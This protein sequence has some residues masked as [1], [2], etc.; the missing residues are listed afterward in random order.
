MRNESRGM[1]LMR[2]KAVTIV[3]T[4]TAAVVSGGWLLRNGA[5][6]PTVT[7]EEGRRL[8]QQVISLAA[9]KFVDTLSTDSLLHKAATGLLRELH[10]PHTVFLTPDRLRR[11]NESTTGLYGGLG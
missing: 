8:F 2:S 3:A 7:P 4:L 10:D 1:L 5:A 11:L 9:T 6:S